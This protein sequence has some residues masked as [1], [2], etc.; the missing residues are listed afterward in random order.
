MRHG[1]LPDTKDHRT[2][3]YERTFG[4][5]VLSRVPDE[6][7]FDIGLTMPD[8]NADG[9]YEAC[10]GYA[11]A[12]VCTDEDKKVY[13]AR[14]LYDYTMQIMGIK[15]G[16]SRY[17]KVPCKIKD[18]LKAV[19]ELYRRD[20]YFDIL[21]NKPFDA[22]DTI[23]MVMWSEGRTATVGTP[24]LKKWESPINGIIS[25]EFLYDASIP[26]HNYKFCGVKKID[27]VLYLIAKSWQGKNYGDK[28]FCYFPRSVVN[29]SFAIG[30]AFAYTLVPPSESPGEI[31]TV[32][33]GWIEQLI[34]L[35]RLFLSRLT[36]PTVIPMSTPTTTPINE[37]E[38]TPIVEPLPDIL[39]WD[40]PIHVR[41]SVR[42]MCDNA[43]LTYSHMYDPVVSD[44]N[45][46]CGCIQQESQ[47]NPKA[48]GKINNNGTKD[49][50]L[51][52]FNNGKNASGTPLW[53]GPGA[54]F[55][56]IEEVLNDP[57]KN[58]RIM[59]REFKAGHANYWSSFKTGAYKQ[60]L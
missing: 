18:S 42:V 43:G 6:F 36:K 24:W 48:E 50:G 29:K 15:P 3:S 22:F 35:I 58:I 46:L 5:T 7:N 39:L 54:D 51:A 49:F 44:K 56:S 53:I 21:D 32:Q 10:T 26:W 12:D 16:D 19:R 17:E 27:G 31:Q 45:I 57:E 30:G 1:V 28:G 14:P 33:L 37:P 8:Q 47:F 52:Q 34:S 9:L 4:S 23:R 41:H 55:A 25:E 59:I 11:Q 40:T 38:P 20:D 13:L 2:Y 60:W